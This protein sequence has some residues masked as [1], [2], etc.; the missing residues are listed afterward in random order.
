MRRPGGSV[1]DRMTLDEFQARIEAL[2]EGGAYWYRTNTEY[3]YIARLVTPEGRWGAAFGSGETL[4]DAASD[5]LS[6]VEAIA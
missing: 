5:L 4:A 6:Q 3:G 1:P 2:G